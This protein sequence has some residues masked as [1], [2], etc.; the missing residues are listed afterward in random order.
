[1]SRPSRDWWGYVKAMIRRYPEKTNR[2]E[3]KAV[4]RAVEQTRI[5]KDGA[6]RL[7]LIEMVFWSKTHTISGAA[8]K[9]PCSYETAQQWHADFIRLVAQNFRCKSLL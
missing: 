6:E 1:M 2:N 5:L 8:Q 4:E 3:R 7:L 9:I